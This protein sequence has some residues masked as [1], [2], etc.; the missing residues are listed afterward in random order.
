MARNHRSAPLSLLF[1]LALALGI[2]GLACPEGGETREGSPESEGPAPTSGGESGLARF[3]AADD[4]GSAKTIVAPER[5]LRASSFEI[6]ESSE[7]PPTP[8]PP[9]SSPE[10]PAELPLSLTAS[11]GT[12]LALRSLT[13]RAVVEAPL[14][15]TELFLTFENPEN[16]VL[17]GRFRI[18][19]PPGATVSRFAMKIGQH[20]QEGEVVERQAARQ[21]YE[22]FLHRRQDPAL[23]EQEAGNSFSARV[24][25]IP[26]RGKKE[27]ILSYS[28]ALPGRDARFLLPL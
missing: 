16:R 24:F 25:P 23:L 10:V 8:E 13:A 12:G 20:W 5:K 26:A 1:T 9:P 17:E 18:T 7:L 22:D 21:A 6:Q 3:G 14:A 27:L 19:L 28:Q 4:P 15:F 11:D 2:G